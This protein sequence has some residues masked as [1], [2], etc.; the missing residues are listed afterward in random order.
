MEN[1]HKGDLAAASE[2]E[3]EAFFDAVLE[4]TL[5]AEMSAGIVVHWFCVAGRVVRIVFAGDRL[6]R[7]FVPALRHLEVDPSPRIDM[8]FHVW[9]SESTGVAMIP[10]PFGTDH[11]TDRGDIWGFNS[12]RV[13][14]A[15]HWIECSVNLANLDTSIGIYW[16]QTAQTLPYWCKASPLRTLFHWW[17]ERQGCQLLHAAAVGN[18]HGAVLITGK[19]GVGKSTTALACLRAGLQ[20]V[21]DDYLVVQLDPRPQVH[22]LYG[23]AKLNPDQLERFPELRE[24]VTNYRLL[25]DEK[26]VISLYPVRAAQLATS[27]ALR[28]VLTP[29]VVAQPE[30]EFHA[31]SRTALQR[32]AAFTTMSQLPHAGRR[33][34]ETIDRL[35][36]TLPGLEI[37]L[38][39]SLDGV[40]TAIIDL[41]AHSN[42]RIAALARTESVATPAPRPLVSVIVPV[43]N[44]TK[45]LPEAIENIL[46]QG[47]PALEIIV[48]DDGSTDAIDETVRNLPVDVRFFKQQNA[49][50]ASARNR[51]IRDASGEFIAFLDVDDLWPENNLNCLVDA[52]LRDP[53]LDAVRGYG[54]LARWSGANSRLDYVGNPKESFPDYIGACLYRRT[55]FRKVGLFDP[56]LQFGEDTDWFIRAREFG[57][58]IERLDQ[59]TL[60]VRRHD[61]NMTRG[62]SLVEL[63]TLRVFKK[64]LDRRRGRQVTDL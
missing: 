18:E 47:Y 45:F 2:A 21:A 40:A 37:R 38:G 64:T 20:Y 23:T 54:Q 31:T 32:A 30:T 63:N 16:V 33:T 35:I 42:S 50:A 52:L 55:A 39:S 4:R 25:Q 5:Q 61:Q 17:M 48:V 10:P 26:A 56:D 27:L 46:G 62:K 59:I 1:V 51:G 14:T 58:R 13:R 43:Y 6:A 7:H 57:L 15:F 8:T 41:L 19:G 34:H 53:S 24:L 22:S 28:V 60:F 9:D 49:G 44:G 3:Q 29:R 12:E 11:F 36:T